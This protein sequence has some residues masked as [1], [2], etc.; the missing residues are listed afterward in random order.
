M[1]RTVKAW[2]VINRLGNIQAP[3]GMLII[4]RTKIVADTTSGYW[5][6]SVV[7]PCTITY[8]DGKKVKK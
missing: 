5:M 2:A 1:K 4:E 3:D 6:N 7:V 8:D